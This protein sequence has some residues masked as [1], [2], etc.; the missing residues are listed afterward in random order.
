MVVE[1]VRLPLRALGARHGTAGSVRAW[2]GTA[3]FG[4]AR[5]GMAGRSGSS[6]WSYQR[7]DSA[8]GHARLGRA[9]QDRARLGLA[10]LGMA[11]TGDWQPPGFEA[12]APTELGQ[13]RHGA[14]WRGE[15]RRGKAWGP[16]ERAGR[17]EHSH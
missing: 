16:T 12:P 2:R 13:A 6:G 4:G 3:W 9:G 17:D 8:G 14:P 15:A 1:R 10:G 11:G 5:H 7:F